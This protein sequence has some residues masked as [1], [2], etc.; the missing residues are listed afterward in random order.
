M[1]QMFFIMMLAWLAGRTEPASR[2]ANPPCMLRMATVRDST[3]P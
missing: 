2:S 3:H 1:S